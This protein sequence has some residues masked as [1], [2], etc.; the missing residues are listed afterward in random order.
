MLVGG[1]APM[2]ITYVTKV[3][4]ISIC[5]RLEEIITAVHTY[6]MGS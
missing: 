4:D 3:R 1:F 6:F 5:V 2:T